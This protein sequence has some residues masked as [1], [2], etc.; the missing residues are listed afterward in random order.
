MTALMDVQSSLFFTR[1]VI[2][3]F[4]LTIIHESTNKSSFSA[5]PAL[6]VKRCETLLAFLK[7][8]IFASSLDTGKKQ[9]RCPKESN[10]M[11]PALLASLELENI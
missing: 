8:R 11:A 1:S 7:E 10:R 2:G 3:I 4:G 5:L 9:D 6:A